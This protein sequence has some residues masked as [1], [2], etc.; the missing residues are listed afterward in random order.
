M[1]SSTGPAIQ[2]GNFFFFPLEQ[3]RALFITVHVSWPIGAYPALIPGPTHN[4]ALT[5]FIY[6]FLLSTWNL[7]SFFFFLFL[8]LLAIQELRIP[9]TKW[10]L[11]KHKTSLGRNEEAEGREAKEWGVRVGGRD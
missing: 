3:R 6:L 9:G 10:Y 1:C 2:A 11:M 7:F 5:L 8:S 4:L